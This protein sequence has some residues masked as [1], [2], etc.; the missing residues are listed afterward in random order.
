M[1]IAAGF[2]GWLAWLASGWHLLWASF[3]QARANVHARR[4]A[5]HDKRAEGRIEEAA[6]I[7]QAARTLAPPKEKVKA[8]PVVEPQVATRAPLAALVAADDAPPRGGVLHQ[9]GAVPRTF[10]HGGNDE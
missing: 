5:V 8:A 6:R 3:H 4:K 7:E 9:I 1:K 2:I 10:A